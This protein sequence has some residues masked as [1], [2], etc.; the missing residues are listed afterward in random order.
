VSFE[1]VGLTASDVAEQ[2]A[3]SVLGVLDDPLGS[4]VHVYDAM[5]D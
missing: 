4:L 2:D 1:R 3:V 5:E